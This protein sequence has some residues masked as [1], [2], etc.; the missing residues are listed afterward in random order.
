MKNL[1]RKLIGYAGYD[2]VKIPR[3]PFFK[4]EKTVKVGKFFITMP[5][6][7][8]LIYTYETQ[9]DFASEI[10][11]ITASIVKKYPG[12]QV[13]DVGAN[14]GDTIA[15]IKGVGNIPII[16]I[17]G[18][19]FSFSYLEKNSRQFQDVYLVNQFL[20]EKTEKLS[21]SFSKAGWN[22]TIVPGGASGTVIELK[23]LD[24]VITGG[25]PSFNNIKLLKID[26]EGFDTIILRGAFNVLRRSKP[27]L[28]LEYNRD[29]MRAIQEEGLS[30]I[31]GL[32]ELGYHKILFFDDRGRYIL[33]TDLSN[34]TLIEQLHNYAD[35][36]Q[37]LIY[38]YNLCIIPAGD[39]DIEQEIVRGES[40][41]I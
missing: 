6:I 32:Q 13:V 31:L 29:N 35:G 38:Y 16:S 34:R 7:N 15:I 17:E 27:I 36:R 41:R 10:G 22:T 24:E 39:E 37:G 21:V 9:Q 20:G 2:F 28:Y 30:T 19:R 12:M 11:R 4:K 40:S 5:A 1:I 14:V 23:T 8:P 3:R 18:D 33:S 25:F 26:T